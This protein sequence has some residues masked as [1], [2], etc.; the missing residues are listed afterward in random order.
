MKRKIAAAL[1]VVGL[2]VV[3]ARAQ[4][5]RLT[6]YNQNFAVVRVAVPLDLKAGLNRIRLSDVTAYLEPDSVI[7]R[8]PTGQYPLRILEQ[9]YRADPVTQG[10]MLQR[11]EGKTIN[12]LAV[13]DGH[14]QIISG[15]IIRSGYV[16]PGPPYNPYQPGYTMQPQIP[17]GARQPII[18]VNGQLRFSLP[19]QP[20][21]P[22]LAE[23]SILKPILSW[24]I[25]SPNAGHVNAQLSYI[26]GG[27]D[28]DATYNVIE[29]RQ[30]KT[31]ALV[32]WVTMHN[33][34]GM[35][36]HN[37]Q[38]D[39]MAGTLHKLPPQP[40][41]YAGGVPG[42]IPGGLMAGPQPSLVTQQPF[43]EYHLYTLHRAVTL[44]NQETKQIEFI[45]ASGIRFRRYYVYDG[46]Y[47]PPN[48]Y[49][50]W[51]MDMIRQNRDYGT[52]STHQVRV[53]RSFADTAANHLGLPLPAGRLRFYRENSGGNLEFLGEARV[54]HT[55]ANDRVRAYTGNAYD[56]SGDRR[57]TN[58]VIDTFRHTLDE[59]FEI[60]LRSHKPQ[61][62]EVRV[63]EHLYRGRTW[64]ILQH[65]DPFVK[66]SSQIIEFRVQV[67]ANGEKTLTYTV[68][69][70]W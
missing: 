14:T 28:W 25:Q 54:Q 34:S 43:D 47:I 9:N 57:R 36:F 1:C 50:G 41:G 2:G 18:E 10:S 7:L 4:Q 21:F 23:G 39:L 58:Y 65:S 3:T 12:F 46:V 38:V 8:D 55:A 56:L 51:N 49:N 70:T 61:P 69:Y 19:G 31:L 35:T 6:I 32:G 64:Q 33:N 5:P 24:V 17:L 11:Y 59:S 37:A 13:Q 45:H 26:T 22:A 42:G 66:Q 68:H 30:G 44:R 27:M 63:I 48:Q 53:I 67:P 29:P 60:R 62:V 20:L 15:K 40:Y 16:P 52:E